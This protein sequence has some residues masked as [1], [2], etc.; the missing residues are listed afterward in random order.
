MSIR[1]RESA[2][3]RS[4]MPVRQPSCPA[5]IGEESANLIVTTAYHEMSDAMHQSPIPMQEKPFW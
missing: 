5:F 1:R 2:S 4:T 3:V